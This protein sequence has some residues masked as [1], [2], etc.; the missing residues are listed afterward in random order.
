MYPGFIAEQGANFAEIL[1]TCRRILLHLLKCLE[2]S[3][4]QVLVVVTISSACLPA[5]ETGITV[6]G[7][8]FLKILNGVFLET[9]P[10]I[11]TCRIRLQFELNTRPAELAVTFDRA[12]LQIFYRQCRN[13]SQV[14]FHGRNIYQKI[15]IVD[16]R[17]EVWYSVPDRGVDRIAPVDLVF[18]II[19]EAVVTGFYHHNAIGIERIIDTSL[20][21]VYR[22]HGIVAARHIAIADLAEVL[23][24]T[25]NEV[26]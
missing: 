19:L 3:Q 4:F 7:K 13:G 21:M 6:S 11:D 8:R 5:F 14:T 15:I 24:D 26:R 1:T 2:S 16:N 22:I 17:L 20:T 23:N 9:A 18:I 12:T 25:G 10:E